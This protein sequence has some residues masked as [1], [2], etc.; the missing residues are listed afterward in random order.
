MFIMSK[1]SRIKLKTCMRACWEKKSFI[2]W[3]GKWKRNWYLSLMGWSNRH[4]NTRCF[5]SPIW[6]EQCGH[7]LSFRG[8][9]GRARRP[10]SIGRV[11]ELSLKR[12]NLFMREPDTGKR[13]YGFNELRGWNQLWY[14]QNFDLTLGAVRGLADRSDQTK[15]ASSLRLSLGDRR[16]VWNGFSIV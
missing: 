8:M 1:H 7:R 5:S 4:S 11:W 3:E 9:C 10:V 2:D 12:K 13:K 16:S 14:V 15:A 6:P